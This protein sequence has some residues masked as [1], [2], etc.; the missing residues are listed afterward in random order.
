L[1]HKLEAARFQRLHLSVDFPVSKFALF[2]C[3]LYRY[4]EAEDAVRDIEKEKVIRAQ[5][6]KIVDAHE[7]AWE[8][9]TAKAG[10][11]EG[12]LSA[13]DVPVPLGDTLNALLI[14]Q[15]HKNVRARW[16]PDAFS[17]KYGAAFPADELD[18]VLEKLMALMEIFTK[19]TVARMGGLSVSGGPRPQPQSQGRPR[20]GTSAG[21]SSARMALP[22]LP[23]AGSPSP[24]KRIGGAQ[25]RTR[26]VT[27]VGV[28]RRLDSG[29]GGERGGL[30]R[31]G[32][33]QVECSCPIA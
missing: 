29:G 25:P 8:K 26:P 18:K 6:Q 1:T 30:P 28:S 10:G 23:E 22:S 32:A 5:R 15:E 12:A 27:T 16:G 17:S 9:F 13:E 7:A 2:K 3:K 14:T 31:W 19:Q 20:P 11:A 4:T 24:H 33:V 21:A